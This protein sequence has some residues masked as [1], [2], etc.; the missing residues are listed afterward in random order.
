MGFFF[1]VFLLHYKNFIDQ[2][3]CNAD[4][5]RGS[6]DRTVSL[7]GADLFGNNSETIRRG[8]F[9]NP[10]GSWRESKFER[11]QR[12]SPRGGCL[13]ATM[14]VQLLSTQCKQSTYPCETGCFYE[15]LISSIS[16]GEFEKAVMIAVTLCL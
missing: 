7:T 8:F 4:W 6:R 15:R 9:E 12:R 13:L 3:P 1:V 14:A 16:K 10:E 5:Q 2:F 11:I